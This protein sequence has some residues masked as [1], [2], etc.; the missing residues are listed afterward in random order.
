M[1]RRVHENGGR[2]VALA[3]AALSALP[4]CHA[5]RPTSFP[6]LDGGRVHADLYG[7]GDDAVLLAHGGRFTKESWAKE[8]RVLAWEGYRVLAID[9]RGRGASRGGP[10]ATEEDYHLDVAAGVRHLRETGARTVSVIGASFGGWAAARAAVE[11]SL[12]IDRLVL[13]AASIDRPEDLP[14][15]K[16]FI[17]AREDFRGEGIPRLPEIRE[18]Y[19]RA[20]GPKELVILE[21]S[22]HAQFVF[23]TAQGERLMSE[24]LRFLSAP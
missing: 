2:A 4:G 14:G 22:A 8:A 19:E 16:L 18:Q 7:R 21:G 15:R 9:F 24:I 23:D 11:L 17:L 20:P 10:G 6:T 12:E 1:V 5:P 3:V 13:L